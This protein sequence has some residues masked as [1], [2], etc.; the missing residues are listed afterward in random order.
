MTF[1]SVVCRKEEEEKKEGEERKFSKG[2]WDKPSKTDSRER[3]GPKSKAWR[4]SFRLLFSF[5]WEI[6]LDTKR[7]R[8]RER[9]REQERETEI[10]SSRSRLCREARP[11]GKRAG[12][13]RKPFKGDR[14]YESDKEIISV[15]FYVV[16]VCVSADI[17]KFEAFV[18]SYP[19]IISFQ[20]K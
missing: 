4:E 10:S 13:P 16:I 7:E 5:W 11:E 9:E 2:T 8:R 15:Y 14:G 1:L 18:Y 3:E 19:I 6:I 12:I 17:S 20:K